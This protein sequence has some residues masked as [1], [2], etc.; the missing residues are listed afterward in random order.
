ML[1]ADGVFIIIL[2][3][4][5]R[6]KRAKGIPLEKDILRESEKIVS[7]PKLFCHSERS[8]ESHNLIQLRDSSEVGMTFFFRKAITLQRSKAILLSAKSFTPKSPK[9]ELGK[10]IPLQYLSAVAEGLKT[11]TY[12]T[13]FGCN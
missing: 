7:H 13:R 4:S 2:Y 8:E 12:A 10:S 11:K 5:F 3:F 9:G 1:F 6:V